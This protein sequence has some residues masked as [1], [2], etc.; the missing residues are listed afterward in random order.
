MTFNSFWGDECHS[1][2][3]GMGAK[4][5]ADLSIT[6]GAHLFQYIS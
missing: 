4:I 1:S 3:G 2:N 6:Q 5:G